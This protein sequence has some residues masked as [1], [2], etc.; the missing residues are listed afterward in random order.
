[1][2]PH[3]S[4]FEKLNNYHEKINFSIKTNPKKF[5]DTRLLFEN[6]IIKTE[7]YRKANRFPVH[8]K[9]QIPKRYKRSAVNGDLYRSWRIS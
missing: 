2:D 5:L 9:S 1:M 3:D 8:L 4:L 7:V 6:D